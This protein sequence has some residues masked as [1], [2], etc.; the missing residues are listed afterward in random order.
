MHFKN[1]SLLFTLL[2]LLF[3]T[4]CDAPGLSG[5]TKKEYYTGGQLRSEF[6][7]SDKSGLTGLLKEYGYDGKLIS[8]VKMRNGVKHGMLTQYDP[9]DRV[10]RQVPYI[11]GK[12]HG[13][14]T[15]F[16]PNGDKMI[17]YTYVN[18]VKNGQAFAYRPDGSIH[19]KALYRNGRLVN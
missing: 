5:N 1:L 10:I 6:I 13:I 4:G 17:T 2:I 19:R 8:S 3:L 14:D 11:N 15:A 18:G 16:Y 7:M 12:V 9:Q